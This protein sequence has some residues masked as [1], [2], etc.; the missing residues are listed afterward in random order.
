MELIRFDNSLLS[1]VY[2]YN[3]LGKDLLGY[4][5]YMAIWSLNY[6]AQLCVYATRQ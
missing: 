5:Q 2:M 3:P 1:R 4:G 6:S